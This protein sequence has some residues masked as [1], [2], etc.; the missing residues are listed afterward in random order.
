MVC[1]DDEGA[2]AEIWALVSHGLDQSD[3]LLFVCSNLHVVRGE[4][5]AEECEWP[6]ALVQNSAKVGAKRVTVY[7]EVHGEF[8]KVQNR[9]RRECRFE[10]SERCARCV[11][12]VEAILLEQLW[13]WCSNGSEVL[14]EAPIVVG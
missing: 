1:A 2:P 10:G 11:G 14:D 3:E 4:R 5:L 9:H 6:S 12:P 13:Q 7:H 8:E